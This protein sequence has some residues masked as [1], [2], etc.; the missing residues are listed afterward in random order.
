MIIEI[1]DQYSSDK[2][3]DPTGFLEKARLHQSKFRAFKL[4]V[5]SYRHGNYLTE[6]DASFGLNFYNDFDIFEEV[7]KRY[8]KYSRGLYANML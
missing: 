6:K 3:T 1:G 8:P 2:I 4:K 7:R 5:T